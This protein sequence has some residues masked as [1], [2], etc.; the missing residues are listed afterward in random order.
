METEQNKHELLI[1]YKNGEDLIETVFQSESPNRFSEALR[2]YKNLPG[3]CLYSF[4]TRYSKIAKKD[5]NQ[6][7]LT[8]DANLELSAK[9]SLE[10]ILPKTIIMEETKWRN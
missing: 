3:F 8:L 7:L 4:D 10:K 2:S 5:I 1:V 9:I 6:L